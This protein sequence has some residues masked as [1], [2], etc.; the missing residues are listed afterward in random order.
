MSNS[1]T[2]IKLEV[3]GAFNGIHGP[4]KDEAKRISSKF[5]GF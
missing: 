3:N 1:I 5:E 2:V 4:S